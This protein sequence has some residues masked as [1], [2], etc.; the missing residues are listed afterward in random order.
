LLGLNSGLFIVLKKKD[1]E[2]EHSLEMHTP[3]IQKIFKDAGQKIKLL[4][5]M[6]G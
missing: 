6:V 3:Y 5:M 4:P 1:E 2:N